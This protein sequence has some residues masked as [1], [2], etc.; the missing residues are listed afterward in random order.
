MYITNFQLF[1]TKFKKGTN[2]TKREVKFRYTFMKI[3]NISLHFNKIMSKYYIFYYLINH[4]MYIF[5]IIY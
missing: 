2:L 4:K 3:I 5:N 1:I